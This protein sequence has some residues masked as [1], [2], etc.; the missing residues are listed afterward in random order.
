[1]TTRVKRPGVVGELVMLSDAQAAYLRSHHVGFP[2]RAGIALL[3]LAVAFF[4]VALSPASSAAAGDPCGTPVASM[5]ACENSQP[6]TPA[7]NWQVNSSDSTIVGFATS[8]SVNIGETES[9]KV[10]TTASSYHI[11]IFRLGYYQGNG[12]RRIMANLRPTASL[13]QSQPACLTQSSTGLF[14]CGNWAESARWTVP[15]TAVSGIYLANLVRDD[16]GGV[17]QI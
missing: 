4:A 10:K 2:R 13:P 11:D 9:F 1:M 3:A 17:N 12:A 15:P 5:I 7:T 16:T 6:G 14:D 8:M